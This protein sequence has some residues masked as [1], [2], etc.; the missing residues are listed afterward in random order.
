MTPTSTRT[1]YE[2]T[3][4]SCELVWDCIQ[5]LTDEQFTQPIDYSI[6][7]IRN[8]VVHMMSGTHRWM[9]RLQDNPLPP[10]LA[11]EDFTS[12]DATKTVWN[13]MK[14]DVL[15]YVY[16]LD[17]GQL[18]EV[19]QWEIGTRDILRQHPRWALLMHIANH[20]TDHRSQIL[21][22]LHHHFGVRTVEHDMVFYL[23][24]H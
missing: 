18:D 5:E 20:A 6:G 15:A 10:H 21:A 2:Y 22:L 7:S 4:W 13:A 12:I 9:M 19:I 14:A 24:Q 3:Y 1:F 23:A 11:F 8:H 17:Q 16:S